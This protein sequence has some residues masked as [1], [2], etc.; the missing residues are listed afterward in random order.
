MSKL[1]KL[2][3]ADVVNRAQSCLRDIVKYRLPYPNGGSSPD[4]NKPYDLVNIGGT[5]IA[6]CD[7]IGFALWCSGISRHFTGTTYI[8]A[9]PDTP[10]VTGGY[11]NCSSLVEEALGFRRRKGQPDYP[12]GRFFKIV[13]RPVP[14]DLIVYPGST[15]QTGNPEHGHIGVISYVPAEAPVLPLV[16]EDWITKDA[17]KKPAGLRIIHCSSSNYKNKGRAVFETDAVL[18]KNRG[19]HFVHLNREELL[20]NVPA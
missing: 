20:R 5:N 18:W 3:N 12:G 10:S 4:T 17:P 16:I 19:A 15:V 8:Q 9:F 13:E 2:S 14:G 11:I 7:C 6:V 1:L